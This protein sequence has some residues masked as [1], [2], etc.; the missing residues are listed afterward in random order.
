MVF[1]LSMSTVSRFQQLIRPSMWHLTKML[2][3]N[4]L[5]KST[6]GFQT[7]TTFFRFFNQPPIK[8]MAHKMYL[9]WNP[10]EHSPTQ[11]LCCWSIRSCHMSMKF[12]LNPINATNPKHTTKNG[13]LHIGID[14]L[15]RCKYVQ[16]SSQR[17]ISVIHKSSVIYL[18]KIISGW[19]LDGLYRWSLWH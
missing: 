1:E 16:F 17:T 9:L 5:Y 12:A 15:K 6:L 18:V 13:K 11:H 19:V 10:D 3:K 4:P 14:G 2:P 8:P 7:F